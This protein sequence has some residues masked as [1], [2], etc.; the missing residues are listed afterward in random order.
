MM[1][2]E[3]NLYA[4][5]SHLSFISTRARD[6]SFMIVGRSGGP[7]DRELTEAQGSTIAKGWI[8]SS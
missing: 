2:T 5:E 3:L 1:K 8:F 7:V 4:S 6:S